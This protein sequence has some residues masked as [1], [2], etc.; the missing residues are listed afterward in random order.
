MSDDI[1]AAVRALQQENGEVVVGK[2]ERLKARFHWV[3]Q[4]GSV[5]YMRDTSCKNDSSLEHEADSWKK[6]FVVIGKFTISHVLC[7]NFA[8]TAAVLPWVCTAVKKQTFY[9]FILLL[10]ATTV[11]VTNT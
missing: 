6:R 2:S 1:K 7:L 9:I 10:A 8:Q 3:V 4:C 5:C 11:Y